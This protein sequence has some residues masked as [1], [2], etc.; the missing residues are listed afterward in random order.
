MLFL[1]GAWVNNDRL[2]DIIRGV[3]TTIRNKGDKIALWLGM[4]RKFKQQSGLQFNESLSL[5]GEQQ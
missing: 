5:S 4:V 2:E 3:V 1:I